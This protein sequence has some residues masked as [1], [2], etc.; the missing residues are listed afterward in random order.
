MLLPS[1]L[2]SRRTSGGL[3]VGSEGFRRR[4]LPIPRSYPEPGLGVQGLG[5]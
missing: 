5:V 2:G 3:G 4:E 1:L